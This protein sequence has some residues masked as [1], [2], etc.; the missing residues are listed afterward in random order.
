MA[1]LAKMLIFCVLSEDLLQTRKEEKVMKTITTK[2]LKIHHQIPMMT[3]NVLKCTGE[4]TENF[5]NTENNL[6]CVELLF[7]KM[8]SVK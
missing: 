1:K 5:K 7:V 8:P 3:M 2:T 6:V 4:K